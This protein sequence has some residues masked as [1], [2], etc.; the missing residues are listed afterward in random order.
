MTTEQECN[1]RIWQAAVKVVAETS[2]GFSDLTTA[3]RLREIH[4]N[5]FGPPTKTP[6]A[7]DQ[8]TY[9]GFLSTKPTLLRIRQD[10]DDLRKTALQEA[11]DAKAANYRDAGN[12]FHF[13]NGRAD[14]ASEIL[15]LFD[16]ELNP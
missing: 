10:V 16:K 5:I 12:R 15:A 7:P 9:F 1:E 4:Y 6:P 11:A 14:M 2:A 3:M 13:L 8:E